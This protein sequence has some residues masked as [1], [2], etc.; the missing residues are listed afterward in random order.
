MWGLLRALSGDQQLHVLLS[1][2]AEH[3]GQGSSG[4]CLHA[5]ISACLLL[6]CSQEL[7]PVSGQAQHP[8]D[9][10][11]DQR[12]SIAAM[13]SSPHPLFP[14]GPWLLLQLGCIPQSPVALFWDITIPLKTSL[15]NGVLLFLL[16]LPFLGDHSSPHLE[17]HPFVSEAE[18]IWPCQST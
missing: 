15:A 2:C 13:A 12:A 4:R 18:I 9:T 7:S 14:P 1:V 16:S 5:T 10:L 17:H 3:H 11:M 6:S 8:C